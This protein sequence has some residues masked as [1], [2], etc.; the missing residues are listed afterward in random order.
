VKRGFSSF[1]FYIAA[2]L[3]F[4]ALAV[5]FGENRR[6]FADVANDPDPDAFFDFDETESPF[7]VADA[8]EA[9]AVETEDFD[10][11]AAPS[12]VPDVAETTDPDEPDMPSVALDIDEMDELE[13][14]NEP[15]ALSELSDVTEPEFEILNVII[16]ISIDFTIDPLEIDG[17]GQIYSAEYVIENQGEGD[18]IVYFTDIEVY[19]AND[20]DFQP[21]SQPIVQYSG[22]N[23]KAIFMQLNFGM[24]DVPSVVLTD[25]TE[26]KT[27]FVYLRA[28]GN[29]SSSCSVSL[30]G[31]VNP[32]P[33]KKWRNGDVRVAMTYQLIAVSE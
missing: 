32:N 18:V 8:I 14:F 17:R 26:H 4:T 15:I 11:P 10:E 27:A 21:F 29:D 31:S 30:S 13:D 9:D 3:L 7:D 6:V 1:I 28:Y 23:L 20:S 2:L 22:L 12:D 19:F 33:Y 5:S 16:P 24:D 25:S